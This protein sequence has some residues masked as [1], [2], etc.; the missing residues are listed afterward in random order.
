MIESNTTIHGQEKYDLTMSRTTSNGDFL[1]NVRDGLPSLDNGFALSLA[2]HQEEDIH[3]GTKSSLE[4]PFFSFLF[5]SSLSANA[6]TEGDGRHL[7]Q[8]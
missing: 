1:S 3:F 4:C 6:A 5:F 2:V 8:L 7:Q